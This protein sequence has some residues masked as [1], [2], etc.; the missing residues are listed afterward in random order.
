MINHLMKFIDILI[1][2]LGALEIPLGLKIRSGHLD[3]G[4][5]AEL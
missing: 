5:W 1:D 4:L 2:M 3:L